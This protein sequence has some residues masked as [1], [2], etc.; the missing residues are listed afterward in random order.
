M[1]LEK[2]IFTNN[3]VISF[4]SF[5]EAPSNIA[6]IK[7]W[8][9]KGNQIPS[10][11]SISF[12]LSRCFTRTKITFSPIN[13]KKDNWFTFK[14]D[15][16]IKPDFNKKIEIFLERILPYVPSLKKQNLIIDSSN[17]FPHSSGIASSASSM[18]AMALCITDW[19]KQINPKMTE[20]RFKIKA[21]FLARLGSGSASR[22]IY[23]P[24]ASWG[25]T[26]HI[27]KSSDK[28]AIPFTQKVHKIFHDFCNTIILID[29]NKKEIS[30]T[31]GHRLMN[32]HPFAQKRFDQANQNFFEIK[33]SFETGDIEKFIEIVESE[34][35]TLHGLMMTSSPPYKLFKPETIEIIELIKNYRMS[36]KSTVC[37][38]L[39]AGPNIHLLYPKDSK[40]DI[41]DFI[42][43]ELIKIYPNLK[44]IHDQVGNGPK[45]I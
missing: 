43:N 14:L 17:S 34:A 30:S 22:S 42:E 32:D 1:S 19:E 36:S 27:E 28:Y 45:K 25:K 41:L 12:L 2:F 3:Q 4:S 39:D 5:W 11:P 40:R 35:L 21:S 33:N 23:G 44:F 13:S 38:T 6:L 10:N 37:F 7:Y 29:D 18:A 26:S 20:E 24:I 16:N 8:G 15:G 9:K 31:E